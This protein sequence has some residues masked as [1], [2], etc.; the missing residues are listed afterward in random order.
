M[1]KEKILKKATEWA[2]LSGHGQHLAL[3]FAAKIVNRQREEKKYK[4][5]YY[6]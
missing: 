6:V 1:K 2:S 3:I 4:K 5:E